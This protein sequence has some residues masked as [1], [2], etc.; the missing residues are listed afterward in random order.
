MGCHAGWVAPSLFSSGPRSDLGPA[1]YAISEYHALDRN[2]HAAAE[3]TRQLLDQ[4]CAD[5]PAAAAAQIRERFADPKDIVHRGAFLELYLHRL[6]GALGYHVDNDIGNDANGRRRPDML[7]RSGDGE[8]YV[9]ATALAGDDVGDP[10]VNRRLD[11]IHDAV[12]AVDAP[13]FSVDLDIADHGAGTPSIKKITKAVQR[14]LDGLDPDE[15][16]ADLAAGGERPRFDYATGGWTFS[17]VADPLQPEHRDYPHHRVLAGRFSD[18][19]TIDDF[20]PLRRKLK[21][22]AG[23]YGVLNMPYVLA[24]LCAGTFVEDRE[25]NAALMGPLVH[26]F[27]TTRG[28]WDS[29][30]QRDG[31]WMGPNGSINAR[32]SAVLTFPRLSPTAICAVEPTLWINP[33]AT[34]PLTDFGPWRRIEFRPTG[35]HIE[36][37][38]TATVADILGLPSRWP[39]EQLPAEA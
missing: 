9:E 39:Y 18:A 19:D 34:R 36:H 37:P 11:E 10:V 14:F 27:D 8:L 1:P 17:I 7:W 31:A 29:A 28:Q 35:A 26:W 16:L 38:A 12:N 4:W 2:P 22:K 15:L 23:R 3:R 13:A 24:I 6:G 32:L 33:W 20:T 25:I 21:K 5:L 30:R